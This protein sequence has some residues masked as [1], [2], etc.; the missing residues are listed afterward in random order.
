MPL[1]SG[2]KD[3]GFLR[4]ISMELM[5]QVISSEVLIFKISQTNTTVNIY[6]EAK[7]R[8]YQPGIR[9]FAKITQE[10]KVSQ[11]DQEVMDFNRNILF[12]FIKADLKN[13]NVV[14]E[15]GDII[16]YDDAY[17]E[18]DNVND[19][20]YWSNRNPNSN[21]GMTQDNWSLHGYDYTIVAEAHQTK[22]NIL[23]IEDNLRTGEP[24]DEYVAPSIPKYL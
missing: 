13:Q 18:V 15:E 23:N 17:F 14:I 24:T 1:Y 8:R 9:V 2:N 16:M 19:N 7:D 12:S 3:V 4:G 11:E 5:H 20:K 10:D 22:K 21:I 6:G